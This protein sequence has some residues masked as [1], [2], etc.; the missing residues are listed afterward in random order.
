[1][2]NQKLKPYILWTPKPHITEELYN[3]KQPDVK[4]L[5]NVVKYVGENT[6]NLVYLEGIKAIL[7]E[8]TSIAAWGSCPEDASCLI[9]PA[10]NQLGKH[11]DLGDLAKFWRAKTKKSIVLG[12]GIQAIHAQKEI[13]LKAGTEA[14][15]KEIINELESEGKFLI[16]RGD[17]TKDFINK[18]ANAPVAVAAGCPSQ[19]ISTPQEILSGIQQRLSKELTSIT[20]NANDPVW[21]EYFELEKKLIDEVVLQDGRYILQAPIHAI[22]AGLL[23]AKRIRQKMNAADVLSFR[24]LTNSDFFKNYAEVFISIPNWR[25]CLEQCDY[26]VGTRIHG[27]MM[28]LAVGIPSFLFSVDRRTEEFAKTMHLPYTS[29][30]NVEDPIAYSKE[31]LRSHNFEEM[32][33]VWRKHATVFNE[34]L[35]SYGVTPNTHFLK[36]W[37]AY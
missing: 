12:L 13:I 3:S 25:F 8:E 4:Q 26:N 35:L 36:N 2:D 23:N 15:L 10:A 32:L 22:V 11:T 33:S 21:E 18:R 7:P 28:S 27:C 16:C 5:A 17:E 31:K 37:T 1:M 14:W 9:F 20:V 6:G 29:D 19:F 30:L 24:E 34:L